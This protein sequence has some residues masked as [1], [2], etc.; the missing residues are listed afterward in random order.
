MWAN[1]IIGQLMFKKVF[2]LV[3]DCHYYHY[4]E[5]NYILIKLDTLLVPYIELV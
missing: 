2:F 3:L 5:F 1:Q 4:Q